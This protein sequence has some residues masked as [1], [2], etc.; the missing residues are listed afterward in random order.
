LNKDSFFGFLQEFFDAADLEQRPKLLEI[1]LING[2]PDP[3]FLKGLGNLKLRGCEKKLKTFH[4]DKAEEVRDIPD[5][6]SSSLEVKY[7]D[8]D[9]VDDAYKFKSDEKSL[10]L[11]LTAKGKTKNLNF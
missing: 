10:R 7:I 11:Y 5:S 1:H 9:N 6:I 2:T 8:D 4:T 3:I